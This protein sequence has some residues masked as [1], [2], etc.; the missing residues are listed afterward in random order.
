MQ[1]PFGESLQPLS[2][3]LCV[4]RTPIVERVTQTYTSMFTHLRE[5]VSVYPSGA[6]EGACETD[7]VARV[8][9]TVVAN[10]V[11]DFGTYYRHIIYGGY[12][13]AWDRSVD[14]VASRVLV[15]IVVTIA[16]CYELTLRSYIIVH[17]SKYYPASYP[18]VE[19]LTQ[20]T[21]AKVVERELVTRYQTD[22]NN[23][24]QVWSCKIFTV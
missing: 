7:V 23:L 6:C 18:M 10:A 9:H 15:L 20:F 4:I 13:A 22:I 19:T 17:L 5:T 24:Q 2:P 11:I 1:Y 3:S 8:G 16:Y 14:D 12:P 21:L